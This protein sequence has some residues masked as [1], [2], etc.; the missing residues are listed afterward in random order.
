MFDALSK[1]LF[2]LLF[3]F[4]Q[5]AVAQTPITLPEA[6]KL[7]QQQNLQ[8]QKQQQAELL[9]RLE[10]SIRKAQRLPSLDLSATSVYTS[11]IAKFDI[12]LA[13]TGG[14]QVQIELGDHQRS[15]LALALRQP[16]FTGARLQ[17]QV[18][19]AQNALLSEE[20]RQEILQQTI[21]H[22]VRTLF[23]RAQLLVR[24]RQAQQASLA[25]VQ[26]AL[27]QARA[28]MLNAQAMAFDTLKIYT[29][30]LQ[31]KIEVEKVA[32]DQRLLAIHMARLLD[33]Q[34][35]RPIAEQTLQQ[36]PEAIP[37]LDSLQ[38]AAMRQRPELRA[39]QAA[40]HA[41]RLQIKLARSA[42]FPTLQAEASYNLGKPGLNQVANEWM[43]YF[44]GGVRLQWNLWRGKQDQHR[45]EQAEITGNRLALEER[46][47]R[48]QIR[49][50]VAQAWENLN[51]VTEQFD[52]ANQ[53][54]L[55]QRERYRIAN[56]QYGNGL[57]TTQDLTD[58][59]TELT[60]AE[61]LRE[62]IFVQYFLARTDL[63]LATGT[64]N[65]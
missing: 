23:Y 13:I 53:L 12:P 32:K 19:L 47:L 16:L 52:L 4:A 42:Y 29:Q 39:I 49:V 62:R 33:L 63:M 25:R 20:I 45:A 8:L 58:A 38:H 34:E 64:T 43:D 44:A 7:A 21:A 46:D 9:A 57:A 56:I 14:R 54:L 61:L 65:Y 35:A 5:I 26:S 2:F 18:R 59:E 17:T 22:Q 10:L 48:Q 1:K 40:Q 55:Q 37:A 28:L 60:Q 31:I 6:L 41:A 30:Q 50:D 11:E 27:G 15:D 3:F 36:P 24:E 51:Y